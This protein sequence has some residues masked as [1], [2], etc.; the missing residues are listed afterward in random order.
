VGAWIAVTGR[1]EL[2]PLIL[3]LGVICWVAGFDI[4]YA[5]QDEEI[6][7]REGLHSM[8]VW[9]GIPHALKLAGWLH[10]FLL[11]ALMLFGSMAQQHF[12]YY[13]FLAP[14]P[15][16]LLY[17]HCSAKTL[18]VAQINR[19]FFQTNVAIGILFLMATWCSL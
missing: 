5:T 19:A 9:L 12:F 8:V 2:P 16:L 15:L 3:A 7:R 10:G 11:I 17:E 1:I 13:L 18:R 6:D 4:I 14:M